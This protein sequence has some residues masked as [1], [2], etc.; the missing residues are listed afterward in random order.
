VP[1][2]REPL[3]KRALFF[4]VAHVLLDEAAEDGP[5]LDRLPG[6]AGGGVVGPGRAE[7]AAATGSSPV[8]NVGRTEPGCGGGGVRRRSASGR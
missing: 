6:E 4:G 5:A 2:E 7:L 1:Q 3:V 8:V